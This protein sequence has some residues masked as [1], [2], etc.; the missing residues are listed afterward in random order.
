MGLKEFFGVTLNKIIIA[1]IFGIPLLIAD[2]TFGIFSYFQ[3][4]TIVK[5]S[6]LILFSYIAACLVDYFIEFKKRH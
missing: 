3:I 1:K 5:V 4:N 2:I 6:I